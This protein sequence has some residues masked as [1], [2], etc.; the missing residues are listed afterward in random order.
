MYVA[1]ALVLIVAIAAVGLFVQMAA[2]EALHGS[3]QEIVLP[4]EPIAPLGAVRVSV[5]LTVQGGPADVYRNGTHIG[6]T[7]Y[8]L[9]TWDGA[10]VD[11]EL[12]RNGDSLP[13][14]FRASAGKSAYTLT[15]R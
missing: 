8:D 11:L 12:R 10:D 9:Q 15:L 1:S 3:K 13:L 6:R 4:L 7:P 14:Q 5:T 2:R